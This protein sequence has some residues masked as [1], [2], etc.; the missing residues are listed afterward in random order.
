MATLRFAIGF[1]NLEMEHFH[2]GLIL[3]TTPLKQ[4]LEI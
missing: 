1:T 3:S 2:L 4:F